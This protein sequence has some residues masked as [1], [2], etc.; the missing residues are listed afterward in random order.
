MQLKDY[1]PSVIYEEKTLNKIYK[2]QQEKLD[3]VN[4][5][6]QDLVNQFFI[7]TS[8]W[9][10]PLWEEEYGV[11]SK[12]DDTLENRRSRVLAKKRGTGTTTVPTVKNICNA[13]VDKTTVVEH[14]SQYYF[15]LLL[16]S[17]SGFHNFL[18]DLMEIIEELKPAHLGVTYHLMA[19]TQSNLYI[20]S[21]GFSGEIINVY[22]WTPNN[23][24]SKVDVYIPSFQP[25]SLENINVYPK[26]AI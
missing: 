15:E 8:T 3:G 20:A 19:T 5:D 16:E 22:P 12:V 10:L 25:S 26:E 7:E 11:K 14:S 24:E 18:E 9:S 13:F 6:I 21:T 2:I 4:V 1:I 17:Y 23:L